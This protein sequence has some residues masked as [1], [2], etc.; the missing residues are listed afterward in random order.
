MSIHPHAENF[1]YAADLVFEKGM[2]VSKMLEKGRSEIHKICNEF[3]K[4]GITIKG[5]TLFRLLGIE[6]FSLLEEAGCKVFGD[7]KLFDVQSTC[8][9]D[10]SM[11]QNISN[12]KILT[13]FIRVHPEV[14]TNLSVMLHDVI[15]APVGPLTD[16]EDKEFFNRGEVDRKTAVKTFFNEVAKLPVNGVVSSPRDINLSPVG[17]KDSHTLIVPGIRPL[18]TFIKGDTNT[19]NALTPA[20]AIEAGADILVVGSPVRHKGST[21]RNNAI[22]ILD[23]IGEAK[24]R[25]KT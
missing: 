7:Y 17:F 23:E 10:G 12:L 4:L 5:N 9:N 15:I 25:I 13:T 1:V 21:M 3:D 6:A 11:L 8:S 24:E 2:T 22:R 19:A 14:F 18:Y 16:L 20:A